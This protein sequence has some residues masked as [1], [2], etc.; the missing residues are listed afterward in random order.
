VASG[1]GRGR[2]LQVASGPGSG[3]DLQVTSGPGRGQ[4]LQVASEHLE[5]GIFV[6]ATNPGCCLGA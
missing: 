1:P 5:V 2:D 4:G 3:R 6:W